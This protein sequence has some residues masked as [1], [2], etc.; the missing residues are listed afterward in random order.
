[1]LWTLKASPFDPSN[2]RIRIEDLR[3]LGFNP[4][5]DVCLEAVTLCHHFWS[6]RGIHRMTRRER[7]FQRQFDL[8]GRL[9]PPLRGPMSR[10]RRNSWFPIRFP[11]AILMIAGGL[12]SFL[13]L[14]GAWMLP[15]G[16]L[17]L[18][19]DLPMLRGP[20]SALIIRT[21]RWGNAVFRRWRDWFSR[22]KPPQA[23]R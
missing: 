7:R 5:W 15:F 10:L 6:G 21:R 4:I 20:I 11:I 8:L 18:A 2:A 1:V 9:V 19:I 16:L 22:K 14:L 3:G 13:P 23:G 12:L 17:L